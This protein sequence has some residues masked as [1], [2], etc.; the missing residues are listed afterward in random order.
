MSPRPSGVDARERPAPVRLGA[1]GR[2]RPAGA[3]DGEPLVASFLVGGA[4]RSGTTYLAEVLDAHPDAQMARPL[5]PE[6]KVF[7]TPAEGPAAYRERYR[8][9][10][11]PGSPAVR[12]EKTSY[13]L[14]SDEARE[15]IVATLP[16]V[17]AVFI[18]REPVARAYSSWLFTRANGLEPLSFEDALAAE[19]HRPSPLPPERAYARPHDYLWRGRYGDFARRW[20]DALGRDSVS[21][22]LYED[23]V[24]D[25]D[26]VLRSVQA[27]AGLEPRD[28]GAAARAP[29]NA[30]RDLGPPLDPALC[31]RLRDRMR[32]HVE[33]T[34]AATGLDLSSWDY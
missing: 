32:P 19:G 27:F 30:A 10:F 22:H 20:I 8:R 33:E 24:R 29:V 3:A 9:H 26:R 5:V 21:F 25:P 15:R 11:A 28:L 2:D 23:L 1:A 17:R 34:A 6:P 7:M 14:E 4:P 16:A 13:Y 31:Q 18:L 12:G